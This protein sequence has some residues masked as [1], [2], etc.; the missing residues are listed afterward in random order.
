MILSC[1]STHGQHTV[2]MNIVM[3]FL[4]G[5]AIIHMQNYLST[6]CEVFAQGHIVTEKLNKNHVCFSFRSWPLRYLFNWQH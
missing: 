6:F 2:Y 3:E 1:S 5:Y 4:K